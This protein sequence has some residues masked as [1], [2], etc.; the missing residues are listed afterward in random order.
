MRTA[1]LVLLL[2]GCLAIPACVYFN[3][4]YN[5][6]KSFREAE[7]ERRKH[8]ETYADWAFDQ[9]GPELQR[10]RSMQADQL[11]DKAVRK[12]S[13]VLDEYKESDLVDDA[14][15]LIGRAYYWRG[16]YLNAQ[17]SFRDLETFFPS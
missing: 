7:K 10:Q 9:A 15:F 5:A 16:E 1:P 4:F 17:E 6:K 3:T 11:Y 12:A 8:E 2:T 14:M 13:K